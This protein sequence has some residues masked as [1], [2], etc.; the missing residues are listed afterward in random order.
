M[1][2]LHNDALRMDGIR[3]ALLYIQDRFMTYMK[4]A[5]IPYARAEIALALKSVENA[6]RYLAGCEIGYRNH[7]RKGN[8]V[9]HV[10]AYFTHKLKNS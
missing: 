10:E 6:E 4:P 2:N 9:I 8:K 3:T 1:R 7:E 5:D